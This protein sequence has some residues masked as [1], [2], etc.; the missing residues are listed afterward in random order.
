ML[1]LPLKTFIAKHDIPNILLTQQMTISYGRF[2]I[3]EPSL[4]KWFTYKPILFRGTRTE[5]RVLMPDGTFSER[6]DP[7]RL[8]CCVVI[9][10]Q[11]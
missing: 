5:N 4:L 1:L 6:E 2:H 11:A 7:T 8:V 3:N 9:I 10:I